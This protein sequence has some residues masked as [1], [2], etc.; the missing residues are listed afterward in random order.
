LINCTFKLY[1]NLR[2]FFD[3][4]TGLYVHLELKLNLSKL[5]TWKW[6]RVVFMFL[7]PAGEKLTFCC[8]HFAITAKKKIPSISQSCNFNTGFRE[9]NQPQFDYT[10]VT[11]SV[12]NRL[13][14]W[15][16]AGRTIIFDPVNKVA[17]LGFYMVMV[18]VQ[19][20]HTCSFRSCSWGQSDHIC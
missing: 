3:V 11:R 17:F 14:D 5:Q 10:K 9:E 20:V 8:C 7:G 16:N 1:H 19:I 6:R 12:F 4:F 15:N 2:I 18:T 13:S